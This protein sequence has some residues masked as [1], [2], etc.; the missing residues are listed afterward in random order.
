[1]NCAKCGKDLP[2]Q[3]GAGRPRKFCDAGCQRAA[4]MELRRLDALI[5]K[6]EKDEC[7]YRIKGAEGWAENS[8]K[9]IKRLEERLA[10]L[11]AAG[12]GESADV[13]TEP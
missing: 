4:A 1:M 5:A 8:A 2:A 9:E 13:S 7:T 10:Q 11:V 3:E 6:L 12:A